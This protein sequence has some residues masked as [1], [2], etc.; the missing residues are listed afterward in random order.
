[1]TPLTDRQKQL[2]FDY[3][4][5]MTT[6][7]EAGEAERLLASS[8]EAAVL[9]RLLT[10]TLAPL[11][12]LEVEPCPDELTDRL[13]ARVA[14]LSQEQSGRQRLTELLADERAA[15]RRIKVPLWRNWSEVVTAAAVITLFVGIL[16]PSVGF[17]RQKYWQANCG[18]QLSNIYSGL[19]N[20]VSDHDGLL[21]AVAMAPGSPWWKVGYQGKENH[22]N[23]RRAWLLVQGGYVEPS[24]FLCPGRREEHPVDF[25]GFRVRD[26]NDFPSRAYIHFSIR[27]GYPASRERGLMQKCVLMADRNPLSEG[28][29]S[30]Y[31]SPL[32]LPLVQK[33]MTSNSLNH[34]RRGQSALLYDGAVEFVRQRHT[35]ISEDDIYTLRDMRCGFQV[36]GCEFPAS[37]AD[38]FLAP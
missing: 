36:R 25:T 5:G 19:R 2:L 23:T 32:N 13:F 38:I 22:S 17:M 15:A 6:E 10:D 16:F 27:I 7:Q 8:H 4:L 11:E 31:T 35:S 14:E 21:P 20:Y 34:A 33:L 28:L 29:P 9:H 18:A 30:D 12:T 24:R 26:F 37:E 3:S 1:M